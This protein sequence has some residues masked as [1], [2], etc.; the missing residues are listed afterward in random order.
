MLTLS[1]LPCMIIR[2]SLLAIG[3]LADGPACAFTK[4]A[5]YLQPSEKVKPSVRVR[6]HIHVCT[7]DS[8]LLAGTGSFEIPVLSLLVHGEPRILKVSDS[9]RPARKVR[10]QGDAWR[11][12]AAHHPAAQ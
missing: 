3:F 8:W 7:C 1:K 12:T 10:L 9:T 6:I 4:Y 5:Q 2:Y 11:G